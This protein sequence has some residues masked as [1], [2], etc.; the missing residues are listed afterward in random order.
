MKENPRWMLLP[1]IYM[2]WG[3]EMIK[4]FQPIEGITFSL[5]GKP[6]ISIS[7]DGE[8]TFSNIT[9]SEA[10]L[11]FIECIEQVTGVKVKREN[12]KENNARYLVK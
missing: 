12:M 2:R 5:H 3:C 11:S 7:D 8:L 9:P 1:F 6:I 4:I 10:A